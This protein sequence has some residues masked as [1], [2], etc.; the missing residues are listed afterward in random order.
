MTQL[1]IPKNEAQWR[2]HEDAVRQAEAIVDEICNISGTPGLAVGIFNLEGQSEMSFHGFRDV[3]KGLPPDLETIFNIGSLCKAFTAV[4]VACLV[5]DGKVS[6]DDRID[7]HL[8]HLRGRDNGAFTLRDLLSHRSG[9]CRSDAL[10]IGSDNRLLIT[11]SQG[12]EIFASLDPSSPPRQDF[13][14]N[15]FGYHALGCV[16]EHVSGT[17]F[18]EFMKK[19][20]FKPLDMSRTFTKLPPKDDENTSLAYM[21]YY[22]RQPRA[23]PSPQISSDTVAFAAGSIRSCARDLVRFYRF[24]LRGLKPG[25]QELGLCSDHVATIFEAVIPLHGSP[26]TLRERSYA[27]GWARTQLP[28]NI[29]L[30]NGNAGLLDDWPVIG[31]FHNGMLVLHHTGNNLGCSS[32]IFLLP[33]IDTGVIAL[34]NALGHCDAADWAAQILLEALLERTIKTPFTQ[35][36]KTAASNGRSAMD[37]VQ[38][39]LDAEKEPSQLPSDLEQYTGIFRHK[40]EIFYLEIKLDTSKY[41]ESL[42]V[43]FQGQ[44]EE[45]YKLR[46]YHYDTFVFNETFD[47]VVRRGQW[48]RPYSFY[49][50][51]FIVEGNNVNSLRWRFDDTEAEGH[52]FKRETTHQGYGRIHNLCVP[53]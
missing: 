16:I 30:V 38:K 17:G 50:I 39:A 10:F 12:L 9:L 45:K 43:K 4:A 32:T 5:E 18:G 15:N 37:R 42:S 33:E 44:D 8:H 41:K 48:C 21:P 24:L 31:S 2:S 7:T 40:T 26:R 11:K 49:K 35:Y 14:Y 46:H 34:G 27:M 29:N 25:F 13:L 28:N 36:A 51:E 47:Q 23:V 1:P 3:E 22:N 53:C 20:I 19:R 6:W 52:I